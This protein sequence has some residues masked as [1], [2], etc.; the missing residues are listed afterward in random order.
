M[1]LGEDCIDNKT[2]SIKV[3]DTDP[4]DTLKCKITIIL[5]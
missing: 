2:A 3:T 4:I 5:N 1:C